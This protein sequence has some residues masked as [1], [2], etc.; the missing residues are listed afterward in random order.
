[1]RIV[2]F[3]RR[4]VQTA[5]IASPVLALAVRAHLT[6]A[7]MEATCPVR[8]CRSIAVTLYTLIVYDLQ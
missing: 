3:C 5:T 2:N 7:R 8:G 6:I 4:P 1:M